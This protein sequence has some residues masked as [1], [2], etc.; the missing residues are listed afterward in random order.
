VLAAGDASQAQEMLSAHAVQLIVSDVMMPGIDGF[1][2]C[3]QLKGN[4]NFSHIPFIL[5]TAKDT[6]PSKIEGL[7]CGSDA[8]IEKPF[9]PNYLKMQILNL[10]KNREIIK[11]HYAHSPQAPLETTAHSKAD[12]EFLN[13][14]DNM[15]KMNIAMQDFDVEELAKKMNLSRPTLYRKVK[16]VT[17]LSPAELVTITRLK[18]AAEMLLTGDYKIYEIA[19]EIGFTSSSVLS[20]AFQKQFG[21][22]P[23]TYVAKK[24]AGSI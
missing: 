13:K 15:I 1:E 19:D 22:S 5:L 11:E 6:L 8:Y 2:L 18:Q 20:R 16:A 12:A 14:L 4:I 10:L 9:S 24:S 3:R 17:N 7:D 21:M 23:S